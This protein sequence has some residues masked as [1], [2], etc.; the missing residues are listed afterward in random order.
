MSSLIIA[1]LI[2]E[3]FLRSID[4]LKQNSIC[5]L[6]PV[7][8]KMILAICN[9]LMDALVQQVD[10]R[11]PFLKPALSMI[12]VITMSLQV[13]ALIERIVINSF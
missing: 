4:V 10:I 8:M 1:L 6:E 2:K 9:L 13:E 3:R 7:N 5:P 12:F 11:R